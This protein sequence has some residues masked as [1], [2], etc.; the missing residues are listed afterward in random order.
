MWDGVARRLPLSYKNRDVSFLVVRRRVEA[1]C[2]SLGV[3]AYGAH[4]ERLFE[5]IGGLEVA[6]QLWVSVDGRRRGWSDRRDLF[7]D[8]RAVRDGVEEAL[9]PLLRN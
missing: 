1:P 7:Q 2:T 3:V 6:K 5:R 9:E 4:G 8:E